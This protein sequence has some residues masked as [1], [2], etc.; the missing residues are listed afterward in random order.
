MIQRAFLEEN[1]GQC[2]YCLSG[3][4]VTASHLLERNLNPDR[5]EIQQALSGHLCRCGAH[6]RIIKAIQKA[7]NDDG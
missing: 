7:A 5:Q 6:N 3:I 1:A 2:G 4:I